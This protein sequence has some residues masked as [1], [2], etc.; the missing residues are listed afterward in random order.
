MNGVVDLTWTGKQLLD[1]FEGVVSKYSTLS[2][3][4]TTS[5]IQVS[6]QVKFSWNPNN[7]NQTRLIT[8]EIGGQQVDV[9]KNY[10]MVSCITGSRALFEFCR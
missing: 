7:V 9:N 2:H 4:A 1:I 5:F 10:T 3:H 8:L 6:K